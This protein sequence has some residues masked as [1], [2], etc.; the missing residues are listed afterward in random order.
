MINYNKILPYSF[1][2]M[3]N[4]FMKTHL[5]KAGFLPVRDKSFYIL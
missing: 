4:R 3:R 1:L 2:Q 5:M